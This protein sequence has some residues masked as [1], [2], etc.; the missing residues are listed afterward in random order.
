[1]FPLFFIPVQRWFWLLC[2]M[3]IWLRRMKRQAFASS[4]RV[5][6]LNLQVNRIRELPQDSKI[7]ATHTDSPDVSSWFLW[8]FDLVVCFPGTFVLKIWKFKVCEASIPFI[9]VLI[10]DV[11]S[12][13]N[14]Q[15]ALG[16]SESSP[17]LVFV[18]QLQRLCLLCAMFYLK[19]FLF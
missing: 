10:W 7:V 14:R 13:P 1:M 4:Y 15:V 19:E 16:A 5:D 9:Q 18:N 11:E 2:A 8:L 3:T 17:D 12:Q 6:K